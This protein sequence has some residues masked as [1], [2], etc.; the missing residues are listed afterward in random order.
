[1]A[2]TMASSRADAASLVSTSLG[3]RGGES[4]RHVTIIHLG[5]A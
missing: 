2:N 1:M 5:G 3:H 4:N